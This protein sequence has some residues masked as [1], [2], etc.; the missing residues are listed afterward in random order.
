MCEHIPRTPGV[1]IKFQR[2]AERQIS[3]VAAYIQRPRI[4]G[5]CNR[6][7]GGVG[8]ARGDWIMHEER[9]IFLYLADRYKVPR[10][11]GPKTSCNLRQS[12]LCNPPDLWRQ[13]SARKRSENER[14]KKTE[15]RGKPKKMLR[16]NRYTARR[17]K[18]RWG[19]KNRNEE[20]EEQ[21]ENKN[22]RSGIGAK[23]EEKEED[24]K[25]D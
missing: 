16:T 11:E 25:V 18:W 24:E 19:K 12:M 6:W 20:T 5:A 22:E 7:R 17:K 13:I 15:R 9:F 23:R 8:L 14:E 4:I 1:C 2:D 3:V 21:K 10:P